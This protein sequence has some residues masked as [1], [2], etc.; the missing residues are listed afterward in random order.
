[1]NPK[2][3]AV[4]PIAGLKP[5]EIRYTPDE[6]QEIMRAMTEILD[7][8]WLVLSKYTEQLEHEVAVYL[9]RKHVIAVSSESA[10]LQIAL[11]LANVRNREVLVYSNSFHSTYQAVKKSGGTP[12]F[13]DIDPTRH[14]SVSAEEI[15]WRRSPATKAV[16]IMQTGGYLHPDIEWVRSVCA[17]TNI[18]LLEDFIHAFGSSIDDQKAG[19]FGQ[20]SAT[21]LYATKVFHAG[22]GGLVVTDD[23]ELARKARWYRFYGKP[24]NWKQSVAIE[25]ADDWRITE[26]QAAMGLARLRRLDQEIA[27]RDRVAQM[28]LDRMAQFPEALI[29]PLPLIPGTRPNW[30]KFLVVLDNSIDRDR[31]RE[32]M[33]ERGVPIPHGC[34]EIPVYRHDAVRQRHFEVQRPAAELFC[35]QHCA[36]PLHAEMTEAQVEYIVDQIVRALTDDLATLRRRE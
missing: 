34:Y 10:A 9:G 14:A 8:G 11:L 33:A 32:R 16:M 36:L 28:Y 3:S 12:T 25:G 5:H 29:R 24:E 26:M 4:N 27:R 19:T 17:D 15:R 7:K 20:V 13:L 21:S 30:Y 22:N 18:V 31:F 6:K 35:A 23:D 1:M 2:P